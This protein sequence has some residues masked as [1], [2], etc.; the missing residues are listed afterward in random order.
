M[1][2]IPPTTFPPALTEVLGVTLT[3]KR[4]AAPLV[5]GFA[6]FIYEKASEPLF[7]QNFTG[8]DQ[9]EVVRQ[10]LKWCLQESDSS[11]R[12]IPVA[13]RRKCRSVLCRADN[14]SCVRRRLYGPLIRCAQRRNRRSR[15]RD[16]DAYV[17]GRRHRR[18]RLVFPNSN[19]KDRKRH[20]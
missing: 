7:R 11:S 13:N 16:R 4:A 2:W 12:F 6:T 20:A 17:G 14:N 10:A 9:N 18:Y 19:Q 1:S 15:Q 3:V 5:V 8:L